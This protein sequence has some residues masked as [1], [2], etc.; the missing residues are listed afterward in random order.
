MGICFV[1]RDRKVGSAHLRASQLACELNKRETRCEVLDWKDLWASRATSQNWVRLA[2]FVKEWEPS[3]AR[4]IKS[5]T[6]AKISYDLVDSTLLFHGEA[7]GEAYCDVDFFI[8]SSNYQKLALEQRSIGV[9][10]E[11]WTIPHHHSNLIGLRIDPEQRVKTVGLLGDITNQL[12][13]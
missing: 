11:V 1:V 2:I 8:V 13:T 6:E 3:L 12:P 10:R 7:H 5:R 9:E 4:L